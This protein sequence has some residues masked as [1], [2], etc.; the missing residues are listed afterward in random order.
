MVL[1]SLRQL[2]GAVVNGQLRELTFP[3]EIESKVRPV[4][5]S[6]PD[7]MRIYRRSLTFLL[8]TAFE[9]LHQKVPSPSI[10]QFP[11]AAITA[12]SQFLNR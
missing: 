12:R 10:I 2:S 11:P 1:P 9:E 7:G 3:I 5:M 6:E 8:E 4:R